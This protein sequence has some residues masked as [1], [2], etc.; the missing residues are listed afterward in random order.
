MNLRV[1]SFNIRYA[2]G[3]I[4]KKNEWKN[5]RSSVIEVIKKYN[6][7]LIGFQEVLY[8]QLEYLKLKLPEYTT[9]GVGRRDGKKKGEFNPIFYRGLSEIERGTFWLSGTPEIS[10]NTW[11]GGS[12]RLCTWIKYDKPFEFTFFNTHFD[13]AWRRVR[14]KSS[15]LM[16]KKIP[17]ITGSETSRIILTGD[18]NM[19]RRSKAYSILNTKLTDSYAKAPGNTTKRKLTFHKFTGKRRYRIPIHPFLMIDYIWTRG[20]KILS[21]KIIYDAPQSSEGIYPSDHWPILTEL[22]I[23]NS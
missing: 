6:P 12:Y 22:N 19:S 20:W 14:N 10:S 11:H 18:F 9:Y 8:Q 2:L 15:T 17:E 13:N 3:D 16:L 5:R 7:D 23:K 4:G 1:M 21:S